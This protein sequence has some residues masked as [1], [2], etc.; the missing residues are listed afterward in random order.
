MPPNPLKSSVPQRAWRATL[1]VG[2]AAALVL[3]SVA[4]AWGTDAHRVVAALAQQQLTP[5]ARAEVDRLLALEPGA[6]LQSVATWADE[7]RSPTTAAWHYLNFAH[8]AACQYVPERHCP[9]GQCVVGAI[10]RQAVLLTSAKS[11]EDRLKAL[12]YLVHLVGDVHQPLHAGYADD[13]GGNTFQVQAFGRGSNLHALWD[14]ALVTHRP[15]GAAQLLADAALVPMAGVTSSGPRGWAEASCRIVATDGFYPN[16]HKVGGDYA[17]RWDAVLVQQIGLA[18]QR[19]AG[20]LN[21]AL[22]GKP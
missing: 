9:G 2:I 19:L 13:R 16:A 17:E 8:D 7:S 21:E 20:L 12:K 14:S 11:D 6:T 10:E 3:P 22:T 1:C 18:G 5:S 4:H 15:G